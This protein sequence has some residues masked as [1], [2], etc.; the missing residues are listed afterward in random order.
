MRNMICRIELT[1]GFV[2]Q[3]GTA[4]VVAIVLLPF[5]II[6]APIVWLNKCWEKANEYWDYP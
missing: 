1:V 3:V 4:I 2:L 5:L 6:V